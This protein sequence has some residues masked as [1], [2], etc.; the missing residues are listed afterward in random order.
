MNLLP[1]REAVQG[2]MEADATLDA[3]LARDPSDKTLPAVIR[4]NLNKKAPVFPCV[5]YRLATADPLYQFAPTQTE[6]GGES[7]MVDFALEIEAWAV[8]SDTVDAITGRLLTLWSGISL[9]FSNGRIY[10]SDKPFVAL[11]L[12]DTELKVNF[13]LFRIL[14]HVQF[15]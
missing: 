13:S 4:G 3:L 12:P 15:S 6:G 14:L 8:D 11:D 1:L 9:T 5:T 7:P 10:Q 2:R